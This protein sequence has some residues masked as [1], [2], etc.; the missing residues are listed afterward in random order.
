MSKLKEERARKKAEKIN[1]KS[2]HNHNSLDLDFQ[3]QIDDKQFDIAINSLNILFKGSS[4]HDYYFSLAQCYFGKENYELAIINY[5][6]S[7]ELLESS[8]IECGDWKFI[9]VEGKATTHPVAIKANIYCHIAICYEKIENYEQAIVNYTKAINTIPQYLDAYLNRG[10]CYAKQGSLDLAI[11]DYD[12]IIELNPNNI[13]AYANLGFMLFAKNNYQQSLDN[14]NKAIFSEK[15]SINDR[16][17]CCISASHVC[18]TINKYDEAINYIEIAFEYA[19]LDE[20]RHKKIYLNNIIYQE[21][22]KKTND[23]LQLQIQQTEKAQKAIREK[24]KEMI[25]FFTHTMRNALATAPESLRQAI[26]LLGSDDYEKNQKH[27]EAINEITGLFST[28][29]LTDCLIDTFKQSIYDT[30]EFKL[31][32]QNDNTGDAS[33]EWFIA[34]ALRQSLN[35]II[36]IEDTT[37]LRKLINNQGELIKPI[38]KAFIEHV[39]PLDINQH[40]IEKFYHWL[41]SMNALE[42]TVEK[43]NVKFGANKIKFSLMFAIS[44]ELILN[45]LKYWNGTGKIQVRWFIEAEFYI[46]SVSNSCKA[47]ASSQ[48][49]GTH[50]GLAFINRLVELLGEQAQFNCNANEQQFNAELKLHK[51]LLEG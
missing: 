9:Y 44:S 2:V 36:F 41:Q 51:T 39:L 8:I 31:A 47:N 21:Q 50:K 46:F 7:I 33:P 24:E 16:K 29:S 45:A 5:E 27:Y 23:A 26:R 19:D 49:A 22:L 6:K 1:K 12:K 38:R 35:R 48:L 18:A 28:I 15:L 13:K 11:N 20:Q 30:Q 17:N 43:S 25:S 40:D 4:Y 34:A 32:W 42:V 37:G 10:N 3:K 14:F